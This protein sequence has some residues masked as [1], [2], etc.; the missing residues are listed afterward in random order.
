[1]NIEDED[2]KFHGQMAY[3]MAAQMKPPRRMFMYLGKRAVMSVPALRE[4]AEMLV[5]NWAMAKPK[6]MRKTPPLSPRE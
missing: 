5:P 6:E 4:F 2:I 1:M 3:P